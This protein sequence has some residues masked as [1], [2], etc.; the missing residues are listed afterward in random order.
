MGKRPTDSTQRRIRFFWLEY[1]MLKGY[2]PHELVLFRP[3]EVLGMAQLNTRMCHIG[4]SVFRPW[5][6]QKARR[7]GR[8][9]D[10]KLKADRSAH[11]R[12]VE[13]AG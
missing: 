4:Q 5:H 1:S 2:L 13:M 3:D 12:A 7:Y 6:S 9:S 11:S 10:G 8:N